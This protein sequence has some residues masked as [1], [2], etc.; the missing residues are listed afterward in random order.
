LLALIKR[1][2][3]IVSRKQALDAGLSRHA[4]AHRLRP[5]GPW[6]L[7][8]PG[9]YLTVTGTVTLSQRITAALLYSGPQSVV[10]GATAL[11]FHGLPAPESDVIDVLVPLRVQRQA[12]A[13]VRPHRTSRLPEFVY[14]QPRWRYAEPAR[15]AADAARWLTGLREARAVI[16]G[17]VQRR[18]GCTVGELTD[19]LHA[20]PV[21]N[22][23]LLRRVLAEVGDGVRSAPEADLRDLVRGAGLSAPLFNPRLY[24]PGGTFLGCPDAWWPEAGLAVEVDSRQWHLS[25]EDWER[26]MSRHAR[27]AAQSIVTLHFSPHQLRSERKAVTVTIRNAYQAGIKRPRLPITTLPISPVG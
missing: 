3:R 27:F 18:Q 16:A 22:S 4:L 5:E 17:A 10:T 11:R 2:D 19:E 21:R 8:L 26:T 14:G 12:I 1:Q 7:V 20:G 25:P 23:A 6:Q 15:A 13:F 24:L 9:V